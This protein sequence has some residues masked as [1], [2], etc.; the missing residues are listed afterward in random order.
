MSDTSLLGIGLYS[1]IQQDSKR[2]GL[3]YTSLCVNLS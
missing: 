2:N 1:I 3:W